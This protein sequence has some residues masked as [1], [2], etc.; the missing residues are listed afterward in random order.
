MKLLREHIKKQISRLMEEKYPLPQELAYAL[1]HD[2][3]MDPLVRYISYAKA[4]ATIP[5]SYEIFLTN[6]QSFFIIYKEYSLAV[7]IEAKEYYLGDLEE[8]GLAKSHLNRLL[9]ASQVPSDTDSSDDTES[10][11]SDDA[12]FEDE[13]VEDPEEEPEV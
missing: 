12:E 2:L 3:K 13:A 11:D 5:P 4:A 9:Q 10:G 6:G 1:K 8:L 7:K